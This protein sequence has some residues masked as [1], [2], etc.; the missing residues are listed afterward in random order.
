VT[1]KHILKG[2]YSQETSI[3]LQKFKEKAATFDE[4]D[5]NCFL[6]LDEMSVKKHLNLR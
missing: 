1:V 4:F 6:C 5:K 3:F 2:I